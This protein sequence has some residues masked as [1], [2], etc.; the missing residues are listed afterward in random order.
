M[1]SRKDILKIC[2]KFTGKHP[3]QST[4]SIKLLSNFIE[5][6]LR[7][8]CFPINLLHISGTPFPKNTSERLL[9][10]IKAVF[11]IGKVLKL[12]NSQEEEKL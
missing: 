9:L 7:Y 5:I 10:S 4:I 2:S 11:I 6:T 12:K 8:G 1:F 3:C